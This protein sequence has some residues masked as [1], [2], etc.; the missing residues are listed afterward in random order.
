MSIT[1]K[2]DTSTYKYYATIKNSQIG[3]KIIHT[4]IYLGSER[5]Y[6]VEIHI[7]YDITDRDSET[8][9]I[10]KIAKLSNLKHSADCAVGMI[11]DKQSGTKHILLASVEFVKSRFKEVTH[12]EFDDRSKYPCDDFM[13]DLHFSS[14]IFNRATWYEKHFNCYIS[15][16]NKHREYLANVNK[17]LVPTEKID[18]I[19]FRTKYFPMFDEV[20]MLEI[21]E[22]IYNNCSNYKC[23]F[24]VI[25][26]IDENSRKLQTSNIIKL[27]DKNYSNKKFPIYFRLCKFINGWIESFVTDLG[28]KPYILLPWLLPIKDNY[29]DDDTIT[30]SVSD[31]ADN[32][33]LQYGGGGGDCCGGDYNYIYSDDVPH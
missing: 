24:D 12:L 4:V 10:M 13:V 32:I 14:V 7:K 8:F 15:D 18:F 16:I 30:I 22:Q 20:E 11:L 17:L 25:K 5:D 33:R 23:F 28:I 3:N 26:K 9:P 19:M 29:L 21:L 1:Y 31:P 2:I 27:H 6:C